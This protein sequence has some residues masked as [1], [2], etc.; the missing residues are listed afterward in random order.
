MAIVKNRYTRQRN[1]AKANVRYITHRKARDSEKVT[2][3]LFGHDG[4]LTKEQAYTMI[5][6]ASKGTYFNRLKLSTDPRKEDWDKQLNLREVAKE[7]V[8]V[9]EQKLREEKGVDIKLDF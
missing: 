7:A 4:K 8:R 9:L 1:A 3:D 5:D 6:S 2:R